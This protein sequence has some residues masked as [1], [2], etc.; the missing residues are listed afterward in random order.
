MRAANINPATGL[1][2]D[3]LNHFN[4]A[5]MLLELVPD[6][7]DCLEELRAWAPVSYEGH[8]E[9][10]GYRDRD[11]VIEAHA[12]APPAVRHRLLQV[13][14]DMDALLMD[15]LDR[16]GAGHDGDVAQEACAALKPLAARAAAIINGLD[17]GD[18]V[19]TLADDDAAQTAVDALLDQW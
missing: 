10:S 7:P 3:Y 9:R 15:A 11:F 18:G 4:E 6:M 12:A 16:L 2:T 13:A 1:A 5:I 19:P 8:F 14:S 17:E